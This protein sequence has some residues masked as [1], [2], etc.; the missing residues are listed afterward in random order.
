MQDM[1]ID[2]EGTKSFIK[3]WTQKLNITRYEIKLRVNSYS[4]YL[5]R[6]KGN[7]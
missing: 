1:A 7:I 2:Y 3:S 5:L 4:F 6:Q